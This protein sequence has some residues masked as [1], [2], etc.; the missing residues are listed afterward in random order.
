M[1]ER[2]HSSLATGQTRIYSP[3]APNNGPVNTWRAGFRVW[4]HYRHFGLARPGWST[5]L[6]SR[7][8]GRVRCLGHL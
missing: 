3:H 2:A 7:N 6:G 4:T 1:D 8:L 5:C